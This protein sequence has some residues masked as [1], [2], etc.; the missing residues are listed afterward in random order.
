MSF[1]P[2]LQFPE[3]LHKTF[4]SPRA[5]CSPLNARRSRLKAFH[6]ILPGELLDLSRQFEFEQ[7]RKDL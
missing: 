2:D 4:L 1:T 5:D 7:G 3:A 6:E